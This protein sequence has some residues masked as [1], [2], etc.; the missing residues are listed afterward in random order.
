MKSYPRAEPNEKSDAKIFSLFGPTATHPTEVAMVS[1][2]CDNCQDV[3]KKPKLDQHSRRFVQLRARVAQGEV[4]VFDFFAVSTD[5]G[6]IK[7]RVAVE[8]L[9]THA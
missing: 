4:L 1:F 3:V 6:Q 7:P 2:V 5:P 8:H 9:H